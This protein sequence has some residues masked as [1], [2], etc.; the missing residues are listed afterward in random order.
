[1]SIFNAIVS[2]TLCKFVHGS[3]MVNILAKSYNLY[4]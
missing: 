3:K 1:L 4:K 2:E